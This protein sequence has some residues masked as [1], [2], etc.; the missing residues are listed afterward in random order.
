MSNSEKLCQLCKELPED[1][2]A[3]SEILQVIELLHIPDSMCLMVSKVKTVHEHR[4]Q[5]VLWGTSL[6]TE[7]LGRAPV[8]EHPLQNGL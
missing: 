5:K 6:C 1:F 4:P 7:A 2:K 8:D 3:Y